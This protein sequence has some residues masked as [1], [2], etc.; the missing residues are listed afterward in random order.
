MTSQNN[1]QDMRSALIRA[2]LQGML[3]GLLLGIGFAS[4]YLFRDRFVQPPKADTSYALLQEAD[5]LM[6]Q[7]FLYEVPDESIRVHGAVQG[8][9]ASYN[10]PY[11][12]FV[13]P[14]SAEVDAGGLAGRFGGIGAEI[15]QDAN[16]SY[17]ITRVYRDN[18]AFEAGI[19][20]GDILV[21]VDGAPVEGAGLDM[22]GVIALLRGE[23]GTRVKLKVLRGETVL[24]YEMER[25]EVLV[26]SAFWRILDEDPRIGYIQLTRFTDRAP[27]EIR[28]AVDELSEQGAKALI[29][30]F[31]NNGG[32]LVDS[33]TEIAGEFLNGGVIL[34]EERRNTGEQQ[35]NAPFGGHA[36]DIPLVVLVNQNTA[37]ASEIVVGAFQ[38]RD[39]A[40][41]IGQKTYGKGSVQL[42]LELSDGSSIHVTTAQWFT[43]E[44]NP[45][46]GLG[47]TPDIEVAPAEGIDAELAAAID[48]LKS[49]LT[50]P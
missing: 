48:Q 20:E 15:A 3:A 5:A 34:Y 12:F 16:G 38:D 33:A 19:L 14:Q 18:P 40:Q 27:E 47:V 37:S 22:D 9:I 13:E 41:V 17:V 10:D 35:F 25:I 49:I 36:L 23:V 46:Q 4:G 45:I 8:L 21:S 32:G 24:D 39:R 6:A 29:L 43:P 31:R 2:V 11:T 30:D 28:Q 50:N 42:I 26:P 7:H 44:H 1:Q